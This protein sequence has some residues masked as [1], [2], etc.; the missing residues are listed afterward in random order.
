M[1]EGACERCR[2]LLGEASRAISAHL[3]AVSRLS[4]AIRTGDSVILTDRLRETI[5]VNS[6]AR[7]VAVGRYENHRSDHQLKVMTAGFQFPL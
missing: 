7:E 1:S 3:A 4:E 2:I 5:R 6:T